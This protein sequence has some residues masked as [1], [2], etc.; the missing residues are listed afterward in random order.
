MHG[1]SVRRR[2]VALAAG[3]FSLCAC[4]SQQMDNQPRFEAYEAAPEFSDNGSARHPPNGSVRWREPYQDPAQPTRIPGSL[5]LLERGRERYGIYCV[6]CHGFTGA[7]NGM[8]V[9]RGFPAPP[10]YTTARLRA[11]SDTHLYDVITTGH[12]VM[13]AY[14]SALRPADRIAVVAYIR[15]LQLSQHADASQLPSQLRASLDTAAEDG[16]R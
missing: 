11:V 6:P 9:Q 8:V 15:A 4:S 13:F 3:V 5:E 16:S 2:Y 7:G 1:R 12:G 14:A 10:A